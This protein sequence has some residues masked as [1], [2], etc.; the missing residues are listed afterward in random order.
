M[1]ALNLWQSIKH[2]ELKSIQALPLSWILGGLLVL[3][4]LPALIR[5]IR[6]HRY[7]VVNPSPAWDIFDLS[8][9]VDFVKNGIARVNEGFT[10]VSISR[11]YGKLLTL[12]P[13]QRQTFHI[14]D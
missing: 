6:G 9:M 3:A 13:V 4:V 1:P 5:K 12:A 7:P 14:E 11:R 2:G 8:S 10:K